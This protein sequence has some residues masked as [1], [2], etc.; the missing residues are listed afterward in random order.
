MKLAPPTGHPMPS[1]AAFTLIEMMISASLMTMVLAGVIYCH[2][3]GG[4]LMQFTQAK[5]G[6]NDSARRAFGKLQDEIR[7]AQTILVG[8]GSATNF[9]AATNGS[10]L[11]GHAGF[12]ITTNPKRASCCASLPATAPRS[13][14]LL[15]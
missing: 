3:M 2:V 10:A 7:G 13:S 4:R 14:S 11:A 6:A 8:E 15:M 1:P 12:V 5:L 9:V